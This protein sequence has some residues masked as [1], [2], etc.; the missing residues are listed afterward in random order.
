MVDENRCPVASDVY[1]FHAGVVTKKKLGA[2]KGHSF[3]AAQ[4]VPSRI[5]KMVSH[6]AFNVDPCLLD[7]RRIARPQNWL[8]TATGN[9]SNQ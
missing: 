9:Q 2:R 3:A 8:L 1:L 4:W 5:L 7:L 6:S